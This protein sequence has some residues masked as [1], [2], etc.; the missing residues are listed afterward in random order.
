MN[1]SKTTINFS[2]KRNLDI[3]LESSQKSDEGA[4]WIWLE[5]DDSEPAIIYIVNSD[6][7]LSFQ[8]VIH[9]FKSIQEEL[10]AHIK[11]EKH[12]REVIAYIATEM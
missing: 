3:T 10:P 4:V 5:C 2:N 8:A 9:T 6:G 12:L 11:N 7:S 1:I